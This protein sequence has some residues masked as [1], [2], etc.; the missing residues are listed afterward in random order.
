VRYD[1]ITKAR[2]P[3]FDRHVTRR[4]PGDGQRLVALAQVADR[5]IAQE[6]F[7]PCQ[8]FLCEGCPYRRPVCQDWHW[9]GAAPAPNTQPKEIANAL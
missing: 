8:N 6:L 7:Y 1:V 5:M 9:G 3:K 4:K 2:Q